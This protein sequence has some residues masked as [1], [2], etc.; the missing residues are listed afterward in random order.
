MHSILASAVALSSLLPLSLAQ[1]S[2]TLNTL[3]FNV[4]GLPAALN[5]NDVPGDKTTN[6]AR[7]GELFTK[8]NI[9]LIHVQEDFN[10]HA[11][12][13]AS[14]KH[15]YRTATSG[16]VPFGSGLNSLSNFPFTSFNRVKWNTCSTFDSADCLTPKG[17]TAMRVKFAEGVVI[18]AYNLHADAGTTDADN[19]ARA[20][21]L[22]QV[23]DYIKTYS[24]GNPVI[25]FGDSNSRY[26]RTNDIPAVFKEQNGMTD[27]WIDLIKKGVPPAKGADALLCSNPSTTNDCEIVDKTWY[28]G[29]AAVKL[30]A[31]KFDYAGHMFLQDNGD[32][33]SD[34]NGVLVDFDWAAVDRFTLSDTFGGEGGNW[35]NDLDTVAGVSG[36]KVASVTLRG[37]DRV[38]NIA[39]TLASG[40]TLA[41]GGTGGTAASLTLASG[42]TLT[43]ATMCQGQRNGTNRLFYVEFKTSA[44]KT[45]ATGAKTSDCV[46]RTAPAGKSIVGLLGRAADGV[47]Q[48]GLIYS[49]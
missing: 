31:R 36:A 46:T 35:F 11:T 47:D 34:H 33:L 19:K 39:F 21:N 22:R 24:I 23:S 9:S 41:H 38:D 1:T 37:A 30:T 2:G 27:V 40:Q 18:D 20:D 48:A 44:G 15:P 10:Y 8:Y 25:V 14:D 13:Y 12:L 6:T 16:G 43:S 32:I 4:A 26:T 5:G 42:E 45:L 29:S 17:F 28:R 49:K 3:T 7:I